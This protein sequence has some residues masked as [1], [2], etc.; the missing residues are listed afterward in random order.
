MLKAINYD[1]NVDAAD[2]RTLLVCYGRLYNFGLADCV[3]RI[4]P[5]HGVA[6]CD[7]LHLAAI[8]PLVRGWTSDGLATTDL[9]SCA[10]VS[11]DV[12]SVS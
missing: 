4:C 2:V 7:A 8:C 1:A 11:Y 9:R 3:L 12:G 6:C 10:H 5:K